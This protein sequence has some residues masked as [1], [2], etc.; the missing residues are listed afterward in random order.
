MGKRDFSD[1][2]EELRY[3]KDKLDTFSTLSHEIKTPINLINASLQ[4]LQLKM[5]KHNIN[6]VL[7][8]E[9][10]KHLDI[11]NKNNLR[12]QK[13]VHNIL[14]MNEIDKGNYKPALQ[15][16]NI[17]EIIKNIVE[18]STPFIRNH[19]KTIEFIT[20]IEEKIMAVDVF[21]LERIIINLISNAIKFTRPGDKIAVKFTAEEDKVL[22]SISDTGK[23]IPKYKQLSIF[24]KYKL[25]DETTRREREG[26]GLGLFIVKSLVQ[27]HGGK[28]SLNSEIDCGSEFIVELPVTLAKEKCENYKSNQYNLENRIKMEFSDIY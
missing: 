16:V 3:D 8:S 26:S 15:N 5:D 1:F 4:L 11:I 27:I 2:N 24:N 17:V 28:I 7:G 13:L 18:Q 19:N 23:G 10:N 20:N 22:I 14:D 21:D 25:G 9:L 6:P 12:L